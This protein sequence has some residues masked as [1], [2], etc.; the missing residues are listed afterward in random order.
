[1]LIVLQPQFSRRGLFYKSNFRPDIQ[2]HCVFKP[3]AVEY[4]EEDVTEVKIANNASML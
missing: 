2:K 1:M 3:Y 4:I